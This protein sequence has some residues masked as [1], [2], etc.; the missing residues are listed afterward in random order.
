ML[1]NSSGSPITENETIESPRSEIEV[2]N[3]IYNAV[4]LPIDVKL[5]DG[6][7]ESYELDNSD[8]E[9]DSVKVGIEDGATDVPERL[10][11]TIP[12]IESGEKEFKI[13]KAEGIYIPEESASVKI[14]VN[15]HEKPIDNDM[16]AE[17]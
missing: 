10:T 11:V 13:D 15:A 8:P 7:S 4:T 14:N 1:V 12:T 17:N 2:E 5:S 6:L 9:P 16:N 3:K